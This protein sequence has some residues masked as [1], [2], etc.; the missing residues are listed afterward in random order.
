M[1]NDLATAIGSAIAGLL[2]A[3]IVANFLTGDIQ[4]VTIKAVDSSVSIELV[5]PDPE[6][7]NYRALNP[8]VEVYIG[9]CA[10]YDE[11]GNCIEEVEEEI[12]PNQED[13]LDQE[14]DQENF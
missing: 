2:I 3:F 12:D 13:D 10:E 14:A 8:T 4:P 6:V 5:D 11:N 1:K 9:S 7:F